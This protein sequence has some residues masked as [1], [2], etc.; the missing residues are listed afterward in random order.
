ML[1]T[2]PEIY[3]FFNL[4]VKHFSL[5][6]KLMKRILP[7]TW[8]IAMQIYGSKRKFLH[9]ERVKLAQV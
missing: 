7:L 8:H 6:G 3:T 4:G 5:E 9:K 1:T 2:I